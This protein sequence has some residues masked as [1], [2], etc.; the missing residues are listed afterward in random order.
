[1]A[2]WDDEAE[3]GLFTHHL[4][5]A[6]YGAG[7]ADGD[8]R[9][10]AVEAK[11]YLDDTMTL[12]ARREFGRHQNASLNGVAGAVLASAGTAGTFPTRPALDAGDALEVAGG[13]EEV[14]APEASAEAVEDEDPGQLG[15]E[16]PEEGEEALG[17]T[18]AQ[19]VGVQRGLAGLG[20]D[21]G[22]ADG[23]F[24]RRTRAAI[25]AYQEE[26][27]FGETGYLSAEQAE[28]LEALGEEAQALAE[29]E[30]KERERL[31]EEQRK[32]EEARRLEEASK[33]RQVGGSVSGLCGVSGAGGGAG[34]VVPD[35][36]AAGR[37]S[38]D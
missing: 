25:A 37:G 35:G 7:D 5:D 16:S 28:A 14:T 17:L 38:H 2:S 6:L 3:H 33:T 34:G 23:L 10:T 36:L 31:A 24:G 20:Y 4:M 27:G 30:E 32:E 1:M 26:K 29:S 18:R 9:V 11:T 12:A 13:Y 22:P 21:V 15:D 19:R 8:G